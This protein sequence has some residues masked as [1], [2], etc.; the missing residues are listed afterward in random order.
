MADAARYFGFFWRLASVESAL[1]ERARQNPSGQWRVRLLVDRHGTVRSEVA[2]LTGP[3][4]HPGVPE[5]V[6]EEEHVL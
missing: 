6:G 3:I 2:A 4:G 5:R 1:I